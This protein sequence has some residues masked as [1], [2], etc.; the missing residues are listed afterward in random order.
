M[1]YGLKALFGSAAPLFPL[2]V[3]LFGVIIF[4]EINVPRM[5]AT[6][7]AAACGYFIIADAALDTR[8]GALG[9]GVWSLLRGLVGD[10]GGH[11]ILLIGALLITLWI[12]DVSL[13]KFIGLLLIG[14]GKIRLPRLP[15]FSLPR[16]Q[17]PQIAP[18]RLHNA[19]RV[20]LH[21]SLPSRG[22]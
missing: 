1:A 16:L 4:L 22:T 6:L 12:T 21:R 5:M 7:G 8:G 3:A 2:L 9:G 11:I 17:R 14:A 20:D 19:Q 18:S 15:A 10:L 13:K